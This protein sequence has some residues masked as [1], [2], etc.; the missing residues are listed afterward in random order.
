MTQQQATLTLASLSW[1]D[2]VIIAIIAFSVFISLVRGF[3]RETLSLITWIAAFL[4]AFNFGNALGDLFKDHIASQ[5]ARLVVGG[6]ILFVAT[7]I[8]GA[9]VNYLISTLVEKTGLTGTDR[10]LGLLLGGARGV[11]IVAVL[12]LLVSYTS[13]PND[14]AW[15][16]SL[17]VPHF[18]PFAKWIQ[19]FIPQAFTFV[20]GQ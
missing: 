14:P 6:S 16:S 20:N 12:I 8:V 3:V 13:I 9:I 17:L 2:Y 1:I 4:I 15:K 7:L 11:L 10:V 18:D 5:T 19:G